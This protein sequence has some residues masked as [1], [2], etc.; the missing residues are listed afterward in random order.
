MLEKSHFSFSVSFLNAPVWDA[1]LWAELE[2]KELKKARENIPNFQ[3]NKIIQTPNSF[4]PWKIIYIELLL[5][6]QT[7]SPPYYPGLLASVMP[8]IFLTIS[9]NFSELRSPIYCNFIFFHW[10]QA[11]CWNSL[12][13]SENGKNLG[14]SEFYIIGLFG[15]NRCSWVAFAGQ[16]WEG[17]RN[18]DFKVKR[19]LKL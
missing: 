3:R 11:P 4:Y 5:L 9:P 13:I 8:I 7:S 1:A 12:K 19:T 15:R 18:A 16:D 14:F 2:L 10:R 17:D 6:H